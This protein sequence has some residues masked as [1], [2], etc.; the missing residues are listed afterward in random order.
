MSKSI[1]LLV[2]IPGSG[3]ST[4]IKDNFSN[5][6]GDLVIINAD[7]IRKK[8]YGD[9]NIQGDG[10]KVFNEVYRTFKEALLYDS[11]QRIVVDNTNTTFKTRKNYY[12]LIKEN[13]SSDDYTIELIFFTNF[14]QAKERNKNRDRV[15]PDEV[16]DRMVSQF[17]L[18]N[19][20]EKYN[21]KI[22][23]I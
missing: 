13:Y 8:F 1:I 19:E 23:I 11:I 17:E 21:C 6:K 14:E 12:Q 16:M 9:E 10:K 3:K 20:W 15:V 7:S 2:G 4:Y 18:A 5:E 22:K